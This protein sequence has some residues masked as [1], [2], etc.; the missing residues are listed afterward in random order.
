MY[1]NIGSLSVWA[2]G[3]ADGTEG[4][5]FVR[6]ISLTAIDSLRFVIYIHI[7]RYRYTYVCNINSRLLLYSDIAFMHDK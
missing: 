5:A 3:A 4:L 6:S 1:M 2:C 7:Y